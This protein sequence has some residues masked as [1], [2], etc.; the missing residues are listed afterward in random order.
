M[1]NKDY[2]LAIIAAFVVLVFAV[3]K[4][5]CWLEHNDIECSFEC[6]ILSRLFTGSKVIDG[7][8]FACGWGASPS[9]Q[10]FTPAWKF[11]GRVAQTCPK[12]FFQR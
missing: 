10:G 8:N 9:C 5:I 7:C 1:D 6:D 4:L 3:R 11:Q 12:R 2:F